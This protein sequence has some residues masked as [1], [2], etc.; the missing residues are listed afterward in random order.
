M[1][2]LR[3]ENA[4]ETLLMTAQINADL[5]NHSVPLTTEPSTILIEIIIYSSNVCLCLLDHLT[6]SLPVPTDDVVGRIF[7]E[8]SALERTGLVSSQ[9][10]P[11]EVYSKKVVFGESGQR[12]RLS[13]DASV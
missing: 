6:P 9:A 10:K 5:V 1:P 13:P 11:V 12:P 7:I 4:I 2:S 8:S 3:D